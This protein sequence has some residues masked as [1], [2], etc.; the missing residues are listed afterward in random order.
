MRRVI[1]AL[2]LTALLPLSALAGSVY[3]NGVRIDG[4]TNQKFEK[5]TSV[6]IDEQGNVYIDAPAYA[7]KVVNAPPPAAAPV[8]PA[9][10]APAPAP[11]APAPA[12]VATS[13]APTAPAPAPTTTPASTPASARVD[14]APA[15]ITRR[16]WLVTEQSVPGMTEYDIDLYINSR[17]VRKLRSGEE[18]VITELTRELLP[19]KNTVLMMAHKV[20]VGTRRSESPQHVFKVIIGEG[21]VGGGNVMI[22]NPL[23]RFQR[24]AAETE[25]LSEEFTLTTQ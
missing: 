1:P 8:K 9:P 13:P 10:V 4:V 24:T 15:R 19:G 25:D 20:A 18:Q 3:L 23:V 17:W 2:V 5:V 16:Y 11:T 14:S 7:V 21:T 22:D 6:R 12:P